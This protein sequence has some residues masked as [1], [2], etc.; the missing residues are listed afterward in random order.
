MGQGEGDPSRSAKQLGLPVKIVVFNNGALGFI[1]L[2]RK[3][4]GFVDTGTGL[5]NPDFVAMAETVGIRGIR[6]ADLTELERRM[7]EALAH[8]GPASVISCRMSLATGSVLIVA[9]SAA[10]AAK[11][12]SRRSGVN[13]QGEGP[14]EARRRCQA[15]DAAG[16]QCSIHTSKSASA[17]TRCRTPAGAQ[18]QVA[19]G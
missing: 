4:S 12:N 1:E 7:A 5:E 3:S 10:K 14:V 15:R 11:I 6:V 17:S 13:P 18:M 2:E 19:A 8:P 16:Y 9:A